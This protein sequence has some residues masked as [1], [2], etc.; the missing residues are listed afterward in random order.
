[1]RVNPRVFD[2]KM[3]MLGEIRIPSCP[4]PFRVE[5]ECI[6]NMVTKPDYSVGSYRTVIELD[7]RLT[8]DYWLEYDGMVKEGEHFLVCRD[9]FV[10]QATYPEFIRRARQWLCEHNYLILPA[11]ILERARDAEKR[12]R[13]SIKGGKG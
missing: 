1:M 13:Q 9:W 8:L 3:D 12:F 11:E 2:E 6:M 7:K 10:N 5:A 4:S